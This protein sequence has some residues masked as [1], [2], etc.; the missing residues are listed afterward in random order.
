MTQPNHKGV[1]GGRHKAEPRG[2]Q[3]KKA[4]SSGVSPA[5]R[6]ELRLEKPRVR[7]ALEKAGAERKLIERLAAAADEAARNWRASHPTPAA[8]DREPEDIGSITLALPLADLANQTAPA[9]GGWSLGQARML[10]RD[11]YHVGQ[12][13]RR[14]GW[15]GYWFSDLVDA[16]GYYAQPKASWGAA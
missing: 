8:L 1:R 7:K 6:R 16:E 4:R 11:G 3:P 12:V 15:G 5:R 10:L 13:C 2:G 14:T 9:D